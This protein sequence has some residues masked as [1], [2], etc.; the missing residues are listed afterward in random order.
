LQEPI[1]ITSKQLR[2]YL[3]SLYGKNV[4]ID[5]LCELGKKTGAAI[6][7]ELK[8]FG[9]GKPYL[10]EFTVGGKK[11][12]VVLETLRV[13]GGFGHDHFSDRA[14]ILLWQHS[15]FNKLPRHVKSIDVGA[16]TTACELKSV[17]DCAEFFIVTELIRGQLYHVDLDRIKKTRQIT[18]LDT[19]RCK[20]LSDYLVEIHKVKADAP[21]LYV[22]KIRDLV[23]HGECIF[24]LTDS[25]PLKLHY[26]SQRDFV[27]IEK[28]CVEWRWKLKHNTHRLSQVHGDFHPWNI[29]FR[30]GTDFTLLDRSRGEWGEPADDISTLTINYLF[31]SLQTYG[32]LDGPFERLFS[33]FWKNYLDKTGDEEILNV[34]Q[35]FYAW[36]GM[37]VASPVW[38]PHLP[39]KVRSKLFNFIKGILEVEKVELKDVNS[40]FAET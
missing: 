13:E 21:E 32:T 20:A 11:R 6:Q 33:L 24:G 23:G 30:Q 2:G 12:S 14:Q 31:Y 16:F 4:S 1:K 27:E 18:K 40:Y 9:Y 25:Y 26:I 39:L 19:D 8:G 7:R 38:Y 15:A 22:R 17:G 35:P 5:C 3:A 10:I 28:K 29:M 37:V 36:R 34:I